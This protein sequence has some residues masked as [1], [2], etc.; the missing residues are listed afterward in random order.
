MGWRN[1]LPTLSHFLPGPRLSS[2]WCRTRGPLEASELG[3]S[4]S[5]VQPGSQT[6]WPGG[7]AG[8]LLGKKHMGRLNGQKPSQLWAWEGAQGLSLPSS[9]QVMGLWQGEEPQSPP[10]DT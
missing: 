10:P 1:F 3:H 8:R 2:H 6:S 5:Q 4:L 7:E 9:Q